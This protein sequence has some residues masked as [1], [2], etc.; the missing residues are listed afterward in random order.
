MYE[1]EQKLSMHEIST[2]RYEKN[3]LKLTTILNS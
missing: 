2:A 1:K 3:K